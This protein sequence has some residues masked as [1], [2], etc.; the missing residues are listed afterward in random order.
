MDDNRL[1]FE[2]PA[3]TIFTTEHM[4]NELIHREREGGEGGGE[5][6]LL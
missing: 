4:K 6:L 3:D 1:E 5:E 2:L